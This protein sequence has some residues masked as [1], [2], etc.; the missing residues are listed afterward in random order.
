MRQALALILTLT[1]CTVAAADGLIRDGLGARSAGR[2]GTNIAFA[3]NGSIFHDNIGG[4]VNYHGDT[5]VE[6][7]IDVLFTDVDYQDA[8]TDSTFTQ[9]FVPL[10]NFTMMKKL[11]P[12]VAVGIGVYSTGGFAA[13]FDMEGPPSFPGTRTYKSFGALT[14]ILPGVSLRMTERLSVGGTLGVG[15][16]HVEL[17]GP[18]TIQFGPLRGTPMLMDT[19][20]TGAALSWSVG[21]QY[22]LSD[23]TTMGLTYQS[24]TRFHMNGKTA[25]EVPGLGESAFD[26][27][28]DM[29]WPRSLGAGIRHELSPCSIAA[30]DLIYYNWQKAY[31]DVGLFLTNPTNAAFA[32]FGTIEEQLPLR[33]RDTLS[34]RL[35]YERVLSNCDR[36]RC[37]YVYHRNPIPAETITP[38]ITPIIEHTVSVGY[39]TQF[40]GWDV[41]FG[42]QYMFGESQQ[43]GTSEIVGGDFDNSEFDTS[44]HLLFVS[45]LNR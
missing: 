42:Y 7:T 26:L 24:E 13:K 8:A 18:Y 2:G 1:L 12:D 29:V 36:F 31:D 32:P 25:A 45:F 3:D 43:V 30:V 40:M 27:E 39:G 17:E 21:M 37:G 41:D 16:S 15:A 4:A 38:Y 5:L 23:Q 22:Q 34:V 10:G 6:C 11:D 14:R 19:Q 33:W 35:G 28:M 20:A 44:V 9:D